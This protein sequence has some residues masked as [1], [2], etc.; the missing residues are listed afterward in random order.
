MFINFISNIYKKIKS[1]LIVSDERLKLINISEN[2][3]NTCD[4]NLIN[5]E[6]DTI[7]L[8]NKNDFNKIFKENN[9]VFDTPTEYY[10]KSEKE[11]NKMMKNNFK[12]LFF[13]TSILSIMYFL[14]MYNKNYIGNNLLKIIFSIFTTDMLSGI[15][16]LTLDNPITKLH[17]NNFIRNAAWQFQE[18]HDNPT[19]TTNPPLIHVLLY[20]GNLQFTVLLTFLIYS[21]IF[22]KSFTTMATSSFLLS[23]LGQWN[24]RVVHTNLTPKHYFHNTT[25]WMMKKGILLNPKKHYLHHQTYD[26]NFCTVTG[27]TDWIVNKFNKS[28]VNK[29]NKYCFLYLVI[30][31]YILVPTVYIIIF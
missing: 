30:Y 14:D 2:I 10:K 18:H 19:D 20:I 12:M 16:H 6:I 13:N 27:W 17:Q 21:I 11:R 1:F 5:K 22:N 4:S 23:I 8:N 3:I 24:H 29:N 28:V 15:I 9:S 31:I 7:L 26:I 25:M